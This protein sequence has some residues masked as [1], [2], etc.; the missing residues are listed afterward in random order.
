MVHVIL[1]EVFETFSGFDTVYDGGAGVVDPGEGND[2][3]VQR[4][5]V[6]DEAFV[7]GVDVADE[8][9]E[10]EEVAMVHCLPGV[11]DD[12]ASADGEGVDGDKDHPDWGSDFYCCSRG[13]FGGRT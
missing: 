8:E 11:S 6:L 7:A 9:A 10:G 1:N 2:V 5:F 12:G 13:F 4:I 3:S